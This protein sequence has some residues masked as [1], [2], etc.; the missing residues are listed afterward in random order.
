MRRLWLSLTL[1]LAL[2]AP[3][4]AQSFGDPQNITVI[5]SGTACVTAPTAC[6]LFSLDSNSPS[7]ALSVVGTWTGTLTFEGTADGTTWVAVLASNLT[8]GA[9]A[10][11]TTAN[12][13]FSI[14]NGGVI[15]VRARATAAVTGTAVVRA[16]RGSG[17]AR[18]GTGGSFAGNVTSGGTITSVGSITSGGN[19]TSGSAAGS[20]FL[21]GTDGT[22]LLPCYSWA[23]EPTLGFYRSSANVIATGGTLNVGNLNLPNAGS[24]FW[25][26]RAGIQS[27]TDG[28]LALVNNAVSI[29]VRLKFD[30]LPVYATGFGAVTPAVVAGSTPTAG[31][32]NVGTGAI[33]ATGTVTFGGTA[34]PSVPFCLC[35]STVAA[36]A[37]STDGTSATVLTLTT[38]VA[39]VASAVIR[40][41]CPSAK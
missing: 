14:T 27:P 28:S 22:A 11:T 16:A 9:Q 40:W 41:W 20:Q 18:L 21:C 36:G 35:G 2:A 6:A 31:A 30:A 19:V 3:V 29:G 33:S 5:D 37:C 39:P 38:A 24:I 34:F 26:T 23:S 10:T 4:H 8:T 17:F 12:G 1:L 13:L 15:R 7:V 25:G 32:I